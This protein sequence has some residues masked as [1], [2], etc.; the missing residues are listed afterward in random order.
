PGTGLGA[1][2]AGSRGL[3]NLDPTDLKSV[4]GQIVVAG[5]PPGQ[6]KETRGATL[7]PFFRIIFQQGTGCGGMLEV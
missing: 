4:F 2:T 7:D 6:R 5:E 3:Q 1:T